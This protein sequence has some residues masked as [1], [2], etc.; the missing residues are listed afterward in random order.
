MVAGATMAP[1]RLDDSV[2]AIL[3]QTFRL[4]HEEVS[5]EEL[6]K[7]KAIIE[8][9]TIYQKETVQGQAR[10]LGFFETVAGGIDYEAEYHKQVRDV[11]P[12]HAA[13]GG[14]KYLR[15]RQR[16]H[17]RRSCRRSRPKK[18]DGDKL[19]T[20]LSSRLREASDARQRASR[21]R[22]PLPV[23]EAARPRWCASSCR[24]ARASSSSAIRR[25][26]WW[27]CAPCGWAAC[28]T[29]TRARTASTT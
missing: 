6:A 26:S 3:E 20:R 24:Q 22:L 16:D 12:A 10:K 8:S 11:T 1:E 18:Q 25:C 13:G 15:R 29:K 19:E 28:A 7:A 27:R 4:C 21:R 14:A 23:A 17:R 9:D 5:D 2:A